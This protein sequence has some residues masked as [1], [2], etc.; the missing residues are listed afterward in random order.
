[1]ASESDRI[2][3]AGDYVLGL[4]SD[5]ER[6]RAERDLEIDPAFRDAVVQLAERMH[7]L[8]RAEPSGDPP[9]ERWELVAQRL[10]ELPQ[11]RLS[12][13]GGSDAKPPAEI[14][15]LAQR[16]HGPGLLSVS[17]RRGMLIAFGLTAAFALGYLAGIL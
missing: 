9:D 8:D 12:D 6:E 4:M 7:V 2:A 11:M 5:R 16:P 10:A 13:L 14:G 3:L 1:M 15:S 17:Y